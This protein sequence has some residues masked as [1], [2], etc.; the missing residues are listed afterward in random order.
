MYTGLAVN[1]QKQKCGVWREAKSKKEIDGPPVHLPNPRSQTH[2]PTDIHQPTFFFLVRFRTFFGKGR[3]KTALNYFSKKQKV[4]VENFFHKIDKK[5]DVSF[6]LGFFRFISDE[7][8]KKAMGV[9]KKLQQTFCKT[10]RV[11]SF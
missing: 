4:H 9:Q 2:P 1:L 8:L 11:E 7:S 10:N 3:S 6:F 5:I